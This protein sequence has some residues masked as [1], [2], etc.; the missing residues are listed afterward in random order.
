M[1][2]LLYF[3]WA[4]WVDLSLP[5]TCWLCSSFLVHFDTRSCS[6][7]WTVIPTVA[8]PTI[9]YILHLAAHLP[10]FIL[11]SCWLWAGYADFSYLILTCT[12]I[13]RICFFTLPLFYINSQFISFFIQVSFWIQPVDFFTPV[14]V[15]IGLLA[16]LNLRI[17][18]SVCW[19]VF[20]VI[21]PLL[22]KPRSNFFS[23]FIYLLLL[24]RVSPQVFLLS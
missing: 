6:S 8:L 22:R 14:S 10:V 11:P 20:I 19:F 21:E 23:C 16:Y 24:L 7:I 15:A 12:T 3:T 1:S 4:H 17:V 2:V 9:W 13:A 5:S 18:W